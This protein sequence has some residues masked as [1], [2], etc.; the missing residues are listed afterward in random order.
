MK[1]NS[2][3]RAA[4]IPMQFHD[5]DS[6]DCLRRQLAEAN[7]RAEKAETDLRQYMAA[8]QKLCEIFFDIAAKHEPEPS[9]R[10]QVD[11]AVQAA[12][13]NNHG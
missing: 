2:L 10:R 1:I 3:D 6:L 5:I 11:S 4:G 13:E 9:I 12:K 7:K 8:A